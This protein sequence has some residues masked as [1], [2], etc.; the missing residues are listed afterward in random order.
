MFTDTAIFNLGAGGSVKG[1]GSK[2]IPL[3]HQGAVMSCTGLSWVSVVLAGVIAESGAETFDDLVSRLSE[4]VSAIIQREQTAALTFGN[5]ELLIAGFSEASNLPEA[6]V[7]YGYQKNGWPRFRIERFSR[8]YVNLPARIPAFEPER[9]AESGLAIMEAQRATLMGAHDAPS[10]VE[11][12]SVG[13][14]AQLT[15]LTR[16]GIMIRVLK[17]WNDTLGQPIAP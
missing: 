13:G 5:F 2:A 10:A 16:N 3:P 12:H 6:H 1:F 11:M 8:Q 7:L 14:A 4:L 17:R 15:T 9:P